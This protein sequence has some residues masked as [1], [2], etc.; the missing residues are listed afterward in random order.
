MSTTPLPGIGVKYDLTTRAQKKHLSVIA[1]RDG[2][3]SL[4]VYRADDPDACALSLQLTGSET[5]ALI[6]A[7]LP[8]HH[9]P[10]VLH[11]TD[12]GLVAER[13]ELSATSYWNGRM[14]G[15]TRIRTET[16]ASI[17]AVLRRAEAI[18]SPTPDF[19]FA[20]GDTLIL[21]G[22]REGIEAAAALLGRE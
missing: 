12:L 18:P 4:N 1:H 22:T 3:R 2:T 17:V 20:G 6:D 11:T 13:V 7:L 5:A 21:I 8:S 10:N 14:L 15:E 16:G 19:R 9:S